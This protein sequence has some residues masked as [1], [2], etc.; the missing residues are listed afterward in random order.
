MYTNAQSDDDPLVQWYD[1]NDQALANQ[2]AKADSSRYTT[3]I[4]GT[5]DVKSV[6]KSVLF[7]CLSR[8]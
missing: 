4:S 1:R 3:P 7:N 6:L 5:T 8:R 2:P